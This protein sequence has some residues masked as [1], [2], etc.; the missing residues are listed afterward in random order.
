MTDPQPSL[1]GA[2]LREFKEV[3]EGCTVKALC[4]R[5]YV[6][7]TRLI[8]WLENDAQPGISRVEILLDY[9]YRNRRSPAP[10][11]RADDVCKGEESCA[12]VFSILLGLGHGELI[13]LF[14]NRGLCDKRL[15]IPLS[16][17][18]DLKDRGF[19]YAEEFNKK[20]WAFCPANFDYHSRNYHGDRIIPICK[21]E[22]I[23]DKGGTARLWQIA[24]QEEFVKESLKERVPNSKFPDGTFGWVSRASQQKC[25][26]RNR[27]SS[28]TT[29]QTN[30]N[31]SATSSH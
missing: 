15:P 31:T 27:A 5:P 28:F 25:R 17:L 20:Q 6:R 26:F 13:D 19:P 24:V 8:K 9:A 7:V 29:T 2:T 16:D 10:P 18:K 1:H 11:L 22:E 21:R 4:G 30:C 12:L 14:E 3:L 23:S